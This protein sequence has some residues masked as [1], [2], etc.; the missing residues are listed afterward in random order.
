MKARWDL[1]MDKRERMAVGQPARGLLGRRLLGTF[2]WYDVQQ[3]LKRSHDP[4]DLVDHFDVLPVRF[5]EGTYADSSW[6]PRVPFAALPG[7]FGWCCC[8]T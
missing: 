3:A 7:A 4:E 8:A 6:G 1:S 5:R 2:A